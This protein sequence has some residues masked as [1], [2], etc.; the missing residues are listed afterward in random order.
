MVWHRLVPW[1]LELHLSSLLGYLPQSLRVLR[2]SLLGWWKMPSLQIILRLQQSLAL[3]LGQ[4]ILQL[5]LLA[6]LVSSSQLAFNQRG[7]LRKPE[8]LVMQDWN[9]C[10]RDLQMRMLA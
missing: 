8:P 3:H 5:V 4:T 1:V 2:T 10:Q 6:L 7:L 9:H